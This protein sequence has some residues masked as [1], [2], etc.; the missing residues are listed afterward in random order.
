MALTYMVQNT[1]IKI[2]TVEAPD[3]WG[4]ND[5]EINAHLS[6][7]A[8][9]LLRDIELEPDPGKRIVLVYHSVKLIAEIV[10]RE[11]EEGIAQAILQFITEVTFGILG[12]S[13][14][15]LLGGILFE[16][17]HFLGESV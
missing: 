6:N 10:G 5:A 16:S 8:T 1:I 17:L 13:D 4:T 2:V 14:G 3:F 12:V 11:P 9:L 15:G 7:E